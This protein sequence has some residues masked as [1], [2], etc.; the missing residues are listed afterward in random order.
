MNADQIV[1]TPVPSSDE[2]DV[3]SEGTQAEL[4]TFFE[5]LHR[6][7]VKATPNAIIRK[8]VG[9]GW[10]FFGDFFIPIAQAVGPTLGVVIV[11]WLQGRAGRKVR[12][13]IG[14]IEAEARTP[15]EAEKLL[16]WAQEFRMN[17]EHKD[18]TKP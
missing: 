12:I 8:A 14:D 17:A 4:R 5:A 16:R 18:E 10:T 9:A 6:H 7:G 11:A 1:L 3:P 15:E 13:K 2:P